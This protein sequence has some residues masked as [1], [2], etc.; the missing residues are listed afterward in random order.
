LFTASEEG[1]QPESAQEDEEELN[2]E[3][4]LDVANQSTDNNTEQESDG[5]VN[6]ISKQQFVVQYLQVLY[7]VYSLL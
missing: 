3:A 1:D 7:L 5:L 4:L 2:P 6:E